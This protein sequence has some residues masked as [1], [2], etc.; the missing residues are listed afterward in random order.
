MG[1]GTQPTDDDL[2]AQEKTGTESTSGSP[3]HDSQKTHDLK[4]ADKMADAAA[5][6]MEE[7]IELDKLAISSERRAKEAEGNLESRSSASTPVTDRPPDER[8]VD[9][10]LKKADELHAA[11]WEA[12]SAAGAAAEDAGEKFEE[13]AGG[14]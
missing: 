12:A 5:P 2:K 11:S 3:G 6:H 8:V 9:H 1:L 4:K 14:K 7:A 13:K 10:S